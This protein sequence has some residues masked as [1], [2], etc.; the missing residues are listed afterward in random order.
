MNRI[1]LNLIL[2]CSLVFPAM[3]QEN[4]EGIHFFEGTWEEALQKAKEENKM[5]FMDCYGSWCGGC[6]QM[7]KK[8][9]PLK[10]V[11]DFYNKNFIC[12]KRN[13]DEEGENAMLKKR[14]DIVGYPTFVFTSSEGY[15]TWQGAGYMEAEQFIALGKK[16]L[17]M[18]GKGDEERFFAQ[19][20]RDKDF[21]KSYIDTCLSYK[22]AD[23]VERIL[24]KLYEEKGINIL[25]DPYYWELFENC[26]ANIDAPL[27]LAVVKDYKKICKMQGEFKV[28]QKIR[29]LY[30]NT[31]QV[32]ALNDIDKYLR[33]KKNPA[34]KEA[35]FRMM[36]ERNVPHCKE[37]QQEINF[38]QL[39]RD[40]K[41]A[42]AYALGNEALA[43]ADARM[44]CNWA[45]L[46]EAL[47]RGDEATRTQMAEWARKALQLG[48]DE[49][50]REEAQSV[51]HDL[52]TLDAPNDNV[53]RKSVTPNGI[54][55]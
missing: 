35:Y 30:A 10:E 47:I 43:N 49:S 48:V 32:R 51:L 53:R 45:T 24:N 52:E 42:E 50:I 27:S 19:G 21:I 2:C 54:L 18:K 41:N 9:F 17:S 25:K 28:D 38:I 14:F 5:I 3:A 1:I 29:N 11:G 26:C 16:A 37:L 13:M 34:K 8:I 23:K 33:K 36:E 6:V 46:G 7:E 4:N 44:L 22:Q 55:F 40:G 39:L 15:I 31:R 20:E 12:L